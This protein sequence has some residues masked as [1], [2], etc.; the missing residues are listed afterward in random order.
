MYDFVQKEPYLVVLSLICVLLALFCLRY[1]LK[2]RKKQPKVLIGNAQYIGTRAEQEDSFSTA[3]DKKAVLAVLA[4]GMGGYSDGKLASSLT[5]DAFVQEFLNAENIYPVDQFL[6]NTVNVCNRTVLDKAKGKRMGAT[7]VAA[8]ISQ[9]NLYWISI[10]DSAIILFKNGELINVNKKHIFE[11]VL[12][13]QYVSGKI[14]EEQLLASPLKKR[15]TSY[16]GTEVLKEIDINENPIK[17]RHGDRVIL[18][19]DGVYNSIS[20]I[21]LEK[22]LNKKTDPFDVAEEIIDTIKKKDLVSQ[23]NATVIVLEYRC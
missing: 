3:E 12:E 14:S 20:E 6:M 17:L 11:A 22:I 9:G 13:N 10:G 18:C 19:S 15:V 23:D 5:V 1:I 21:E 4:D 8:L 7:V 2:K 16:I